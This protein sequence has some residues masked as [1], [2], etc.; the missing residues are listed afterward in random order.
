MDRSEAW[1]KRIGELVLPTQMIAAGLISGLL[2]FGVVAVSLRGGALLAAPSLMAKVAAAYAIL[3][4]GI[5]MVIAPILER[6]ARKKIPIADESTAEEWMA[7]TTELAQAFQVETIVT[8]AIYEGAGFFN[9]VIVMVEG[10]LLPLLIAAIVLLL[11]A[12]RFPT[13]LRFVSWLQ[14]QVR[15][16]KEEAV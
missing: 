14:R 1:L 15:T 12:A 7:A 8:Y 6:A 13:R 9:L 3:S 10:G 11:M 2:V 4:V 16:A 5:S